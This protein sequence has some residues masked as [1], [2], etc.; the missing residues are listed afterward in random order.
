MGRRAA[1]GGEA[2]GVSGLPADHYHRAPWALFAFFCSLYML[3]SPG[4]LPNPDAGTR[5]LTAL[6][7]ARRGSVVLHPADFPG[8]R[9]EG[10]EVEPTAR[11]GYVEMF[12]EGQSLLLAPFV[13]VLDR[14]LGE[15]V[16]DFKK[17]CEFLAAAAFFPALSALTV[18]VFWYFLGLFSDH[19]RLNLAACGVFGASTCYLVYA[20]NGQHEAQVALLL[21]GHLAAMVVYSRGEHPGWLVLAGACLGAMVLLR[22]GAAHLAG[23]AVLWLAWEAC[24][25]R[26]GWMRWL[27]DEGLLLGSALVCFS[28]QFFF[29][30]VKTGSFLSTHYRMRPEATAGVL[31]LPT[32]EGLDICLTAPAASLFLYNPVLLVSAAVF[33]VLLPRLAREEFFPAL[34]YA[35]ASFAVLIHWRYWVHNIS[36][37][38]RLFAHTAPLMVI[39]AWYALRRYPWRWLRWLVGLAFAIGAGVQFLG[40]L[41]PTELDYGANRMARGAIYGPCSRM[42]YVPLLRYRL[43]DLGELLFRREVFV[44]ERFRRLPGA[45]RWFVPQW[46]WVRLG[47]HPEYGVPRAMVAAGAGVEAAVLLLSGIWLARRLG[48]SGAGQDHYAVTHGGPQ[49]EQDP[50]R[51]LEEAPVEAGPEEQ[52]QVVG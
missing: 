1:F 11:G 39:P 24:R 49:G 23:V 6:S 17:V 7:L 25:R 13:W 27:R 36:W 21:L 50:L 9:L 43:G 40:T 35:L 44:P 3:L 30:A 5:L 14:F 31:S 15:R 22:A 26:W 32:L 48:G 19:L 52:P 46:W 41:Y 45:E 51:Q 10:F 12:F 47:S 34:V 38:P 4:V 28:P 20:F 18:V 37:G 16:A 2:A 33:A 8:L 42:A 29:N